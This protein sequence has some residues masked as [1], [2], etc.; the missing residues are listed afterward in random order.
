VGPKWSGFGPAGPDGVG[1]SIGY[2]SFYCRIVKTKGG[3]YPAP[4]DRDIDYSK[5]IL[6]HRSLK[7]PTPGEKH[8]VT[9]RISTIAGTK[10]PPRHKTLVASVET[11]RS[12][13]VFCPEPPAPAAAAAAAPSLQPS[14]LL[15]TMDRDALVFLAKLDEQAE[16]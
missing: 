1:P 16:R 11:A 5:V 4:I 12:H 14:L 13:S 8:P 15:T 9:S 3:F 10:R 6:Y 2:D 7:Q